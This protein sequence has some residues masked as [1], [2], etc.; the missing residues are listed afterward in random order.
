MKKILGAIAIAV[1]GFM[2]ASCG[3]TPVTGATQAEA[4]G[5]PAWVYESKKDDTGLYAVGSG[6]LANIQ[7]SYTMA[8]ANGRAELARMLKV[9]VQD[10]LQTYVSDMGSDEKRD[11]LTG[12]VD[13][14][15]QK[16]DA[17]LEGSQQVDR[18]N[19]KDGTIY[20]LMYLPYESTVK[21]LNESASSFTGKPE[22]Y[23]TEAKMQEAY[24]KYFSNKK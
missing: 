4:D 10:V 5:L 21:K 7:N 20:V 15:L 1:A 9:Q 2:L 24:D 3:S 8:K 14:T 12:L 11:T 19:A 23:I 6:K 16:T 17:V 18:F 22:A 13:N